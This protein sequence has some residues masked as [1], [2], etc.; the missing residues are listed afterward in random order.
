LEL[1]IKNVGSINRGLHYQK[2]FAEIV[3]SYGDTFPW[4]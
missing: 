3:A 4:Q 1:E 2:P